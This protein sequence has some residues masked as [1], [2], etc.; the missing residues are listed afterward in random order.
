MLGPG[1]EDEKSDSVPAKRDGVVSAGPAT[2]RLRAW[3]H[4][5]SGGRGP[6]LLRMS[7]GRPSEQRYRTMRRVTLIGALTNLSLASAQLVGGWI[8]QSQALIADGAH[9]LSDLATDF[10]VLFAA[11]KANAEADLRHPYGHGR[12]ETLATVG[13]GLVLC[14]VAFGIVFD[15]ARRLMSPEHLMQPTPLALALA[16]LAI[17]SKESLYHYTMRVAKR[18]KSSMLEANA[19]HHRS[20]VVSSIV[21][22]IG[23]GAALAG[24][25]FMDAVAAVLVA[26][27]IGR[28]GLKMMWDSA[29]ELIDTGVEPQE[30]REMIAAAQAVDGVIGAHALRTRRMAG[31]LLAD[32]HVIVAPRISVSEGHLISESVCKALRTVQ[33]DLGTIL[34]HIDPEDDQQGP[35]S[36]HLPGRHVM[37]ERLLPLLSA[38]G[39]EL[40]PDDIVLHYLAGRVDLELELPLELAPDHAAASELAARLERACRQAEDVGR[41]RVFFRTGTSPKTQPPQ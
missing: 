18:V 3:T 13:V 39:V 19:W 32:V 40:E 28:M 34:V 30:Q 17:I 20:D 41:V 14:A 35:P 37:L 29:F 31:V 38:A 24:L 9:T 7:A 36:S 2:S 10:M 25:Q 15:S 16:A 1:R 8:S 12:I 5:Y 11:G 33:P 4:S 6:R 27:L 26:L 21:V 23:V 22:L